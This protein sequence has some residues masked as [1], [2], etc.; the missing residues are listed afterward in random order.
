M[1]PREVLT[2][3]FENVRTRKMSSLP[4]NVLLVKYVFQSSICSKYKHNGDEQSCRPT[5]AIC[6]NKALSLKCP[7]V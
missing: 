5:T 1:N 7:I 6:L 2:Q 4:K 3:P